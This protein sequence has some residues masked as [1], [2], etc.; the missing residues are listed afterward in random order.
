LAEIDPTET[1]FATIASILD[2]HGPARKAESAAGDGIAPAA[3]EEIEAA[4]ETDGRDEVHLPTPEPVTAESYSRVGPGPA[5]AL[6]FRWTVHRGDDGQFYVHETIGESLAPIVTGPFTADEA[7]RAVD[8]QE[9]ETRQQFEALRSEIS[10]QGA[11]AR[12]AR[13]SRHG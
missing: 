1:A 8:Q 5:S 2:Y 10:G 12:T 11:W 7:V 4:A 6:R 13:G 9:A 3:E